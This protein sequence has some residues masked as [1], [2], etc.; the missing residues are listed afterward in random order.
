MKYSFRQVSDTDS[1]PDDITVPEKVKTGP[2]GSVITLR[3][4]GEPVLIGS[5]Q[6]DFPVH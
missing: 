3:G 1:M 6:L 2:K 5:S 4:V